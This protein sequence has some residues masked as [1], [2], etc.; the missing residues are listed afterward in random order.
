[1]PEYKIIL[2]TL[3]AKSEQK[4]K[5]GLLNIELMIKDLISNVISHKN[6][7]IGLVPKKGMMKTIFNTFLPKLIYGPSSLSN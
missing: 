6:K 4:Y 5:Y 3:I 1:M 7:K 2:N